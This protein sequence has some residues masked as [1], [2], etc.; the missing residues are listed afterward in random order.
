LVSGGVDSAV[1]AGLLLASGRRVQPLYVRS[2][3]WWEQ[4]ERRALS[5]FLEAIAQVRLSPL[6]VLESPVE[7]LY[8]A[9]HWSRSGQ[10]VPDAAS[11]DEAVFLPGRNALLVLRAGLWCS[12]NEIDDLALAPL[13]GNPFE[14]AS[15]EFFRDLESVLARS[16]PRPVRIAR[17]FAGLDKA[18]VLRLAGALPVGLTMSCLA[19]AGER[20][21]GRCNKCAERRAAFRAAGRVDDTNYAATIPA[22][23]S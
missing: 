16:G 18:A 22:G 6:V 23:A 15:T 20:H 7:D 21:C 17:P 2:G 4:A 19:P 5:R 10:G 13:D 14:D 8:P 3:L 9:G 1:L 11:A 12:L